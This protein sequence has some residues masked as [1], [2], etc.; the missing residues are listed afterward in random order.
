MSVPTSL[1]SFR[2]KLGMSQ[3]EYADYFGIPKATLQ[4][5]EQGRRTP[6][7]YTISMMR[8]IIDMRQD[9]A[10]P[11]DVIFGWPD[12]RIYEIFDKNSLE[13]LEQLYSEED[14][15]LFNVAAKAIEYAFSP[16]RLKELLDKNGSADALERAVGL[17]ITGTNSP[18]FDLIASLK[19]EGR[20]LDEIIGAILLK[21]FR[22]GSPE[23]LVDMDALEYLNKLVLENS[24]RETAWAL[25]LFMNF[26]L[27]AA[28]QFF[29]KERLRY[30]RGFEMN[31]I[32]KWCETTDRMRRQT[33][34]IMK[35]FQKSRVE[36]SEFAV[37]NG[38]NDDV[39][40]FLRDNDYLNG[41]DEVIR[42]KLL[43][44]DLGF[45]EQLLK[46]PDM[47]FYYRK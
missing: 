45:F 21:E 24:E 15:R 16:V 19:E 41:K 37:Q 18:I 26:D 34:H 43:A 13:L 3:K 30:L 6:P 33:T 5:W 29:T 42:E 7:K 2:Q 22:Q 38:A 4:D 1:L 20:T 17:G 32:K 46:E 23:N 14:K 35:S 44:G 11:D 10:A 27:D 9:N 28:T 47:Q 12:G 40:K 39:I 8:R 31:V 25:L 36:L